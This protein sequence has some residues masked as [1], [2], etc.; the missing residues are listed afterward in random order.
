MRQTPGGSGAW[1]D[2]QLISGPGAIGD[3]WFAVYDEPGHFAQT[4]VPKQR[5]IIFVNDPPEL[6]NYYSHF[7][8]QF[9]IAVSPMP[10]KGF[11]GI[12]LQQQSCQP[13][14]LFGQNYDEL[15]AANYEEKAFEL[16]IVCSNAFK[17]EVQ[18]Q[19]LKFAN[20]LKQIIGDRLHW[21]GRG[22]KDIPSK[23][24]AIAP[25]RYSIA[26]ENNTIEHFW[27][28]KL[29]DIYLGCAFPF[30]AGGPN[31]QRY[32]PEGSFEYLDIKNPQASAAKIVK[33]MDAGLFEQ[34]LPLIRA[35]RQK[36]LDEY[37]FC[38]VV[39]EIIRKYG[40]EVKSVPALSKPQR[41]LKRTTGLRSWALDQPRRLNRTMVWMKY[42]YPAR[43]YN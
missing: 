18:R 19:R 31:L 24:Q 41:V 20:D 38:N 36:L 34:R 5:R 33:A 4:W 3:D 1:K 30:Y 8:N 22:I 2:L 17:F 6:K 13:W 27:T 35:A 43:Q 25:Y 28:E 37:N 23:V 7:L 14:F 11:K 39:W 32:F 21:Y 15:K 40:P 10:L 16:S 42:R 26:L 12:W 29:A 9:G